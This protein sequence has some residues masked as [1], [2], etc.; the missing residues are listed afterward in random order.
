M[1][2]LGTTPVRG[3]GGGEGG[4]RGGDARTADVQQ[5]GRGPRARRLH[6]VGRRAAVDP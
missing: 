5:G 1:G 2:R 3:R 4:E 6:D